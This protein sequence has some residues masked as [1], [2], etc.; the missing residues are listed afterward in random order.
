ML[1]INC[2]RYFGRPGLVAIERMTVRQKEITK[3]PV[4]EK[5]EKVSN[6]SSKKKSINN[7]K[8]NVSK[9]RKLNSR[10]VPMV[11]LKTGLRIGETTLKVLKKDLT[12]VL[13]K[14]LFCWFWKNWF[15]VSLFEKFSITP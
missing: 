7:Q 9:K 2:A 12:R 5:V 6:I 11:N 3:E 10:L 13:F 15:L 4:L 1:I 14:N 8:M